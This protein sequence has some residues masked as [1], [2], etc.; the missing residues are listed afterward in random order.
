MRVLFSLALLLS[1]C[2]QASA[3]EVAPAAS[4]RSAIPTASFNAYGDNPDFEFIADTE[5]QAMELRMD[6][7]T[8]ASAPYSPPQPHGDGARIVSGDLTVDLVPERCAASGVNY[9]LRVTVQAAGREAVTGCGIARWDTHLLDLMPYIDA[10][11][12][13]S[14]QTR[15]ITYA[16]TDVGE[17][18]TVRMLGAEVQNDCVVP[19]D[20]LAGASVAQRG[21]A[22]RIPGESTAVFVRGPGENPGGECYDAPEVRSTS[23]ELLGWMLDPMGC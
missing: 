2:G 7:E 17:G 10:C 20:D 14:P 12:A 9:P 19:H 15:T 8:V 13:K 6:Y 3:P 1:A 22:P 4:E 18:V 21:E 23:G 5:A 16:G 11:L